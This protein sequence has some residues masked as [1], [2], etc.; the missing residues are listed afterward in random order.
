MLSYDF[1]RVRRGDIAVIRCDVH[2]TYG[3]SG[4]WRGRIICIQLIK[5]GR[6][7]VGTGLFDKASYYGI[8]QQGQQH[9]G[10]NSGADNT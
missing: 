10:S 1:L 4:G 2:K 6:S 7:K 3:I 9:T 5:K 8:L